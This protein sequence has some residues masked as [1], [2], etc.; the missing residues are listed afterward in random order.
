MVTQC[1]FSLNSCVT[2][3]DRFKGESTDD[4]RADARQTSSALRDECEE[5]QQEIK[6]RFR[7]ILGVDELYEVAS[8]DSA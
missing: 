1:Y 4:A 2:E 3:Y 6:K 8:N 7:F 5:I